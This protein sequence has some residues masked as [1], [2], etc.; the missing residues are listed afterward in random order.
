MVGPR[1]GSLSCERGTSVTAPITQRWK[2]DSAE[3]TF[4][5]FTARFRPKSKGGRE[6][7]MRERGRSGQ[8]R[9]PPA[10]PTPDQI[11]RFKV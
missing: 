10:P 8:D 9:L 1:G 4:V 6:R 3:L 7:F 5:T 2:T 11:F